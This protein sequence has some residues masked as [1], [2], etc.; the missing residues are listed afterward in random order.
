[1]AGT[2]NRRCAESVITIARQFAETA[3]EDGGKEHDYNRCRRKSMVQYGYDLPGAMN[4]L[5][6]CGT[7]V[8][9]VADGP[10]YVGQERFR[11]QSGWASLAFAS[12]WVRPPR[13]MNTTS[14]FYMHSDQWRYEKVKVD[15]LVSPLYKKVNGVNLPCWIAI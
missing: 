1:M 12:D 15:V 5:I 4:L 7:S 10:H 8:S 2:D 11:P 14:Y 13:H 6:L 3:R 9:R